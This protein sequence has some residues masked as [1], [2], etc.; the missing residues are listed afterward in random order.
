MKSRIAAEG[1]GAGGVGPV[2]GGLIACGWGRGTVGSGGKAAAAGETGGGSQ[3]APAVAGKSWEAPGAEAGD[4]AR[5]AGGA[6]GW[7]AT[8]RGSGC[9]ATVVGTGESG[10]PQK[11]QNLAPAGNVR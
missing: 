3:A 6:T 11:P 1:V 7:G 9:G 5:D 8:T 10:L 4:A 2:P